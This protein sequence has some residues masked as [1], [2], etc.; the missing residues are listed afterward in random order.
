MYSLSC[1]VPASRSASSAV[2]FGIY[3]IS[4]R[5]PLELRWS[6]DTRHDQTVPPPPEL[7]ERGRPGC[8]RRRCAKWG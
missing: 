1:R 5:D 6:G 8:R 2:V 3:S 7:E 4:D